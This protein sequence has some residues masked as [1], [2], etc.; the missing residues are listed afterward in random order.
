M[1][2][3]TYVSTYHYICVR[4]LEYVCPHTD[5]CVLMPLYVSACHCVCV[6]IP[7]FMYPEAHEQDGY[8]FEFQD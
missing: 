5:V 7:L 2:P 4:I 3:H 1:C 8:I 6:L